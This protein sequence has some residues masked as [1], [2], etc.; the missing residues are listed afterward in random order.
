MDPHLP[1]PAHTPAP[2]PAS[3]HPLLLLC[4][5]AGQLTPQQL[6]HYEAFGF[7]I[8][9]SLL[10]ADEMA[11][12]SAEFE[13]KLDRMYAH[14]PYDDS[15]R[16]WSGPCLDDDTPLLRGFTE[17]PRFVG[18]AQQM[19]GDDVFLAGV[20]GNRYTSGFVKDPDDERDAGFTRWHPVRLTRCGALTLESPT[21]YGLRVVCGVQDHGTDVTLDCYGVK[22]AVCAATVGLACCRL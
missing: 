17:D 15:M 6:A 8:L 20:D 18:A 2:T 9:R 4:R 7:I 21:P 19:L 10:S 5:M 1:N 3:P 14:L 22:M 13:A 11:E 16:H 12:L